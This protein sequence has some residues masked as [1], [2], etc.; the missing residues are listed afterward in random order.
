M[1]GWANITERVGEYQFWA[2]TENALTEATDWMVVGIDVNGM[3][4]FSAPSLSGFYFG[5]WGAVGKPGDGMWFFWAIACKG[6]SLGDWYGYLGLP[7]CTSLDGG[8]G[9][10]HS[11]TP[12]AYW[13]A[14]DGYNEWVNGYF[15]H[16]KMWSAPL[17]EAEFFR[18]MQTSVPVRW[19]DLYLWSPHLPGEQAIDYG[20]NKY[21]WTEGGTFADTRGP[22]PPLPL[23]AQYKHSLAKR[24]WPYSNAM[25][26]VR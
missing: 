1:C 25:R 14:N 20:P 23:E 21:H 17:T 18:E 12:A 4:S 19:N 7:G 24:M 5:D 26:G 3:I 13:I 11:F 2:G 6:T 8:S 16:N 15:A 10:G 22:Q 9:T